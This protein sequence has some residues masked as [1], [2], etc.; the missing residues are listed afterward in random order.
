MSI[1]FN[2]VIKISKASPLIRMK[3]KIAYI[4]AVVGPGIE[5]FKLLSMRKQAL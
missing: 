1:Q 5:L 3:F 4:A 2:E